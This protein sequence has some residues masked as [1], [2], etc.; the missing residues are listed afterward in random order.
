MALKHG[1]GPL[2]PHDHKGGGVS[3]GH[4]T[5][6]GKYGSRQQGMLYGISSLGVNGM[7]ILLTALVIEIAVVAACGHCHISNVKHRLELTTDR[8]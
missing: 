5:A 7:G 8:K 6:L 2:A 1:L 3:I 4:S